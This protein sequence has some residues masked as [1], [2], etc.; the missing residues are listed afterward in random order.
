MAEGFRIDSYEPFIIG[1][2]LK[3]DIDINS[4]KKR[5]KLVLENNEFEIPPTTQLNDIKP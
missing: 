2:K 5:M 1:M 4:I 3:P